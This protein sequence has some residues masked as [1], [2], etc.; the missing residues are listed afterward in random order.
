MARTRKHSL[1]L[2]IPGEESCWK[3]S[4]WR[5][6]R[7]ARFFCSVLTRAMQQ[8]NW[9]LSVRKWFTS[10]NMYE[11][12]SDEKIEDYLTVLFAC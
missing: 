9:K 3:R 7:L 5:A 1:G 6:Q 4:C 12:T 10:P 11:E 8:E 2:G